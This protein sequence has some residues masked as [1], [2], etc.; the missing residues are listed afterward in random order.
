VGAILGAAIYQLCVGL[1]WP[2]VAIETDLAVNEDRKDKHGADGP[3][4]S[5]SKM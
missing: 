3:Y 4:G 5:L 1:H 2:V